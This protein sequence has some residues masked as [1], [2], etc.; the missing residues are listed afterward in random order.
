MA[1]NYTD[2]NQLIGK[3]QFGYNPMAGNVAG[4]QAFLKAL[5]GEVERRRNL[6]DQY[7]MLREKNKM[8]MSKILDPNTGK[9]I[10]VA[11]D[12]GGLAAVLY[13]NFYGG[14]RDIK[15]SDNAIKMQGI[16][17]D[18]AL[19]LMNKRFEWMKKLQGSKLSGDEKIAY[20]ALLDK[21]I[22]NLSNTLENVTD[23]SLAAGYTKLLNES[24]WKLDKMIEDGISNKNTPTKITPPITRNVQSKT[25]SAPPQ[26]KTFTIMEDAKGNKAKV[27][28]DG[29]IEEIR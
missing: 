9:Y 4:G 20:L 16:K 28:S 15:K 5:F 26:Q 3:E 2:P 25:Q 23:E 12:T 8:G 1:I 19:T 10:D 7:N 6:Q 11:P 29:T 17:A 22:T 18:S 24:I 14:Q 13:N 27:Y 21:N